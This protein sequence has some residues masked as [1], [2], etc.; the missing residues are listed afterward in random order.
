MTR[1]RFDPS[2]YLVTDPA[3]GGGRPLGE[4]VARAVAGGVTLVQLR[5]KAADG[6]ALLEQARALIALLTPL[7]VPLIVNDRVD[8]A[9]AAGAAGCHVGQS[10]LPAAAARALLG[11]DAILG[12]L[13]RRVEQ[14]ARG[15]SR[16]GRLRRAWPVRRDRDQGR[17]RRRGRRGGHRAG[18]GADRALPL[19]AIGGI[20]AGNLGAAVRAGAD[21]IAVVSAIM[22]AADPQAAARELARGDRRGAPGGRMIANVLT[23]AGSDSGGGAGIQADL[24]TFSALGTYG[25]S[26]L[27]AL[28]AQNTRAVTAIHEVPP[29]FVTAQLD[30][31]FDDIEIAA[32]KIGMLSSSGRDRGGGTTGSSAIARGTSCS[33]R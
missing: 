6:R 31:V 21:G 8:V 16:G 5:D 32:V 27:A 14:A 7:G 9:V 4:I 33:T 15:R 18:A 28:T 12:R 1:P 20:D 23:I 24:K 29:A 17:C 13:A 11:P 19:V 22:A 3:L 10:D 2:L 30:A 26:V 25:C